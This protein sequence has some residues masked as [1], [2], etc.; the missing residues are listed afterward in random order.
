MLRVGDLP[1]SRAWYEAAL[2][3][4]C[5]RTRD[6]PEYKYSLGFMAYGPEESS[7]V[8]ELTYNYGTATYAHG[9]AHAHVLLGTADVGAA[10]ARAA[11]AGSAPQPAAADDPSLALLGLGGS[12]AVAVTDPD[13]YRFV[14][15]REAAYLAALAGGRR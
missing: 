10:A 1:R 7:A 8:M 3:M 9:D 14:F 2:G 6:T 12:D 11:A 4:S 13:G 5:V 15:V